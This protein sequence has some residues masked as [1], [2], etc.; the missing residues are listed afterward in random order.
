MS[1]VITWLCYKA[2]SKRYNFPERILSG[3]SAKSLIKIILSL[4]LW[5]S[6]MLGA[7]SRTFILSYYPDMKWKF[8]TIY[9]THFEITG[10]PCNL[11]GSNWCD[12]F[13][14][15]TIFSF[16][17]H[18]FPSQWAGYTKNKTANQIWRLVQSNRSNC[19]KMKDKEYH[20]ANFCN[21]CRHFTNSYFF[22]PRK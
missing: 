13:T 2:L 14:N 4:K 12:L 10:G 8:F 16:K 3:E 19:R 17:S 21:F 11:I 1:R 7:D 22:H 5:N 20:V 18:L 6:V 9:Y 15:C